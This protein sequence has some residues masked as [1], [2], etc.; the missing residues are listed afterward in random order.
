MDFAWWSVGF[1]G[2]FKTR[3]QVRLLGLRQSGQRNHD[4]YT[5]TWHKISGLWQFK[6]SR[7]ISGSA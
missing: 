5:T 6:Y 4:V 2:G 1:V 3:S 7:V